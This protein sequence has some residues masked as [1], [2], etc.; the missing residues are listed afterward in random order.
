MDGQLILQ[1]SQGAVDLWNKDVSGSKVKADGFWPDVLKKNAGKKV[2]YD[3][4]L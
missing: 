4:L 1:H 2:K 3:G